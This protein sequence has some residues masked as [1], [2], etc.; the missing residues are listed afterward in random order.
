MILFISIQNLTLKS[1]GGDISHFCPPSSPQDLDNLSWPYIPSPAW[2]RG[3]NHLYQKFIWEF[4]LWHSRLQIGLVTMR[5]WV[6]S[7]ASLSGLR[8]WHCCE[9]WYRSQTRLGSCTAVSMVQ[10]SSYSS[11]STPILVTSICC[12]CGP[13]KQKR[14][15]K[16]LQYVQCEPLILRHSTCICTSFCVCVNACMMCVLHV[17]IHVVCICMHIYLYM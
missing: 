8:S 5:I 14:K 2:E 11:D 16:Q 6:Q 12:R 13:E 1:E 3:L 10:A 9:L 15:K 4:P 7:L 17:C